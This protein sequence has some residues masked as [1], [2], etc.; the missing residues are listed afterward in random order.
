MTPQRPATVN[1]AIAKRPSVASGGVGDGRVVLCGDEVRLGALEPRR[2]GV[3]AATVSTAPPASGYDASCTRS[4]VSASWSQSDVERAAEDLG[5]SA[6]DALG[7]LGDVLGAGDVASELEQGGRAL[8]LAAL[9]VVQASVLER[10]GRVA[11]EHLEHAQVVGV[12]LVEPELGDDDDAVD[13][14]AELER[15]REQRLLDLGGAR[16]LL[17]ELAVGRVADEERLAGLGDA[18]R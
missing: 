8:G 6:H 7:D 2:R 11:R 10:D 18:A 15:H 14:R 3:R 5:R 12:E 4:P 13:A 9:G 16:D 1:G 17:A